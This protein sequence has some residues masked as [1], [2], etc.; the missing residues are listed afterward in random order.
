MRNPE[1]HPAEDEAHDQARLKRHQEVEE[2]EA[3]EAG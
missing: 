3:G 1:P 2:I